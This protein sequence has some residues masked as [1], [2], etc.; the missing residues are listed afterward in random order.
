M[1]AK[2]G[3]ESPISAQAVSVALRE[4]D[5]VLAWL[6]RPGQTAGAGPAQHHADCFAA[7]LELQKK[8]SMHPNAFCACSLVCFCA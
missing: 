5:A 2:L 8:L 6:Q 1:P 3:S 7:L 4:A